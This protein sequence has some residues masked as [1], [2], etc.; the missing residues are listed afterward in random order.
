[1]PT[2]EGSPAQ[3][4]KIPK[5]ALIPI[6]DN[7][8]YNMWLDYGDNFS[9]STDTETLSTSFSELGKSMAITDTQDA[10][11]EIADY[12][13]ND[14]VNDA[15]F[16]LPEISVNDFT[17]SFFSTLVGSITDAFLDTTYDESI[18]FDVR[19]T[20]YTIHS[21]EFDILGKVGLGVLKNFTALF[22]VFGIGYWIFCDARKRI[23]RLKEFNWTAMF[24]DDIS[25]D[26]L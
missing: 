11:Q 16:E 3:G 7:S 18:S 12:L 10:T 2:S 25:V 14:E 15:D 23:M 17:L 26:M 24:A 8:T 13:N 4:W 1:M 9:L 21:T 6:Y 20:T 22:W 5:S 19:G